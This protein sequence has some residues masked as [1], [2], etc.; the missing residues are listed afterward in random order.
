MYIRTAHHIGHDKSTDPAAT[1]AVKRLA[2]RPKARRVRK[3]F[4][5]Y[6]RSLG[7]TQCLPCVY[8]THIG[9]AASDLECVE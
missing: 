8:S 2:V 5:H 6:E 9:P 4:S 7:S 1:K 3:K